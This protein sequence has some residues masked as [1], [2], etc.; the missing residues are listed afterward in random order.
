MQDLT[1]TVTYRR[2]GITRRKFTV[3][4]I[5]RAVS[6]VYFAG[7]PYGPC[8][9]SIAQAMPKTLEKAIFRGGLFWASEFSDV[10]RLDLRGYG[11][12]L[13]EGA[14]LGALS[15]QADW[16]AARCRLEGRTHGHLHAAAIKS[17]AGVYTVASDCGAVS[18]RVPASV[19][20]SRLESAKQD[21]AIPV[22]FYE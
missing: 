16:K 20:A 21:N 5:R 8:G 22:F 7:V 1:F 6:G 2:Y 19:A 17:G 10:M 14:D 13:R 4:A 18:I 12:G 3:P 11:R 9:V 15:A